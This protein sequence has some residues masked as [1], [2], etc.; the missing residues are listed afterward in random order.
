MSI[1]ACYIVPHPP[2]IIPEIGTGD[3]KK[4][5]GTINAYHEIAKEIKE[6][7]PDTII[8]SSPHALTYADYFHISP[9]EKFFQVIRLQI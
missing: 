2:L 6:I 7:E 1:V 4:I 8:I 3:E 9:I 5:Q